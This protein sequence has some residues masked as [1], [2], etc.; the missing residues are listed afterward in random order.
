MAVCVEEDCFQHKPSFTHMLCLKF[1]LAVQEIFNLFKACCF[2]CN[3]WLFW[4]TTT[5]LKLKLKVSCSTTIFLCHSH[6]NSLL[7]TAYNFCSRIFSCL[8]T[9]CIKHW[10][11]W[12]I[13]KNMLNLLWLVN[14]M[15]PRWEVCSVPMATLINGVFCTQWPQ[16]LLYWYKWAASR[17]NCKCLG[18]PCKF[19]DIC[20]YFIQFNT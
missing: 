2:I 12:R 17:S 20:S 1:T 8:A 5:W 7:F 4:L 9:E 14:V 19:Q 15:L 18:I 6:V 13:K 16:I 11:L 3:V 10:S